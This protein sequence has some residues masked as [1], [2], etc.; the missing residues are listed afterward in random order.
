MLLEIREQA[1]GQIEVR[2]KEPLQRAA[3]G[4]MAPA[5]P[6][7]CET[8]QPARIRRERSGM[9]YE[10]TMQCAAGALPGQTIGV[11]GLRGSKAN[12]LLQIELRD[13]ARIQELLTGSR[14]E[15]SVPARVTALELAR[16]YLQLGTRH[17]LT[18]WD[19]QLFLL[20][21][22]LLVAG[23][24]P[25]V[26]TVT[27]FT[28]GHALTLSLAA[29]GAVRLDP[30]W[31]EALIALSIV[32]LAAELARGRDPG[33]PEGWMRRAPW[34]MA[35]LFGLLH[36]LGF[37]AALTE[38]GLPRVDIPLA[39][40]AFN[41]GIELGQLLFI[42]VAGSLGLALRAAVIWLR[43]ADRGFNPARWG[44]TLIAYGIGT[45]AAYWCIERAWWALL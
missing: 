31:I 21:L 22:M 25:L 20:G 28:L 40:L 30:G 41:L 35:L 15:I 27:C 36:G 5:M 37:A 12:V 10:W 34:M 13:G 1:D 43:S 8:V 6:E 26:L 18:G 14:P 38:I 23:L 24:R 16:R 42:S 44:R 45:L 17:L 32:L 7:S 29:L 19:H 39:L 2:W 4:E 3:G 11:T 33:A 9:L